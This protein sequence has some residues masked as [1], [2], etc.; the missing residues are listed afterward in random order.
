MTVTVIKQGFT[1]K[2][3]LIGSATDQLIKWINELNNNPLMDEKWTY[4][5]DYVNKSVYDLANFLG[6]E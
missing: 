4:K 1:I 2:Q 6:V 5:E 3:I